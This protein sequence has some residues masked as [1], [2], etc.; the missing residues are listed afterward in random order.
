[1][2]TP[3]DRRVNDNPSTYFV[4]DRK[5]QKELNRVTI[6]DRMVTA[7]MGGVLAEQPDPTVFHRVLDVGCGTG[8]WAL[9]A[10]QTYPTMLL[11]GAVPLRIMMSFTNKLLTR[12]ANLIFLQH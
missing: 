11:V 5:N 12:C 3:L 4:Q 10:G 2:P 9:E 8:G 7:L 6:Q 1:M